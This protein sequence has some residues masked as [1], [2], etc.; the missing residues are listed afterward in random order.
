M[1]STVFSRLLLCHA[2][3]HI[4][5]HDDDQQRRR[6]YPRFKDHPLHVFPGIHCVMYY[7]AVIATSL[8]L[9]GGNPDVVGYISPSQ[10]NCSIAITNSNLENLGTV[11]IVVLGCVEELERLSEGTWENGEERELCSWKTATSKQ[12]Y[13]PNRTL[14]TGGESLVN[15]K[16]V[17]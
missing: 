17:C 10:E 8:Q 9:K 3:S 14:A 12:G 1:V 5:S 6:T 16:A 11:D 13:Q 7:A 15:G 4:R 2:W